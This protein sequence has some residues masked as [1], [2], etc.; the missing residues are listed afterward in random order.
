[1]IVET[2]GA[3]ASPRDLLLGTFAAYDHSG[4]AY[5]IRCQVMEDGSLLPLMFQVGPANETCFGFL[6]M[7]SI[8]DAGFAFSDAVLIPDISSLRVG[9]LAHPEL[10]TLVMRGDR[11][12]MIGRPGVGGTRVGVDL[13]TGEIQRRVGDEHAA[14]FSA[15]RIARKFG[16][17]YVDIVRFGD[18]TD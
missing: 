8:S 16:H 7:G 11:L 4:I 18:E 5:G 12:L 2:V 17:D 3:T 13:I 9:Y 10:G 15:W 6:S 1:M 14:W